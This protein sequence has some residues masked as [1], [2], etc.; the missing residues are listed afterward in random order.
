MLLKLKVIYFLFYKHIY[1]FTILYDTALRYLSY[2]FRDLKENDECLQPQII[3]RGR[4]ENYKGT[5]MIQT[6]NIK[7]KNVNKYKK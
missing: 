7:K 4:I 2:E 1:F 3:K 5:S 6:I